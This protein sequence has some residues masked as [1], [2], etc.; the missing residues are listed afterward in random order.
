MRTEH[1]EYCLPEYL[2][3]TLEDPL[4]PGVEKHL[5]YCSSC[6]AELTGLRQ[7]ME[8]LDSH[9][10]AGPP[11]AYFTTVL[12]RVRE[13]LEG[14]ESR[15]LF[16]GPLLIRL[17]LPIGAAALVLFILLSLPF[18]GT[19]AETGHN[20]LQAVMHGSTTDEL[21]DVVLDMV[22]LQPLSSPTVEGETSSLLGV[23]VLRGDHLLAH[24][25]EVPFTEGFTQDE[26]MPEELEQLTEA[27]LEA[28]VQRLGERT[29]L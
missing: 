27:D 21:V 9:G 2:N 18:P 10:T 19:E 25:D 22:P 20:P 8:M 24:A 13:R 15:N 6:S 23:R 5:K 28:L 3:G 29:L 26:M 1:V 16:S 17:A 14:E 11:S 12:P 7:T 4:R